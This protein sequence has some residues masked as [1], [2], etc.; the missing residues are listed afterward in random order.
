VAIGVGIVGLPVSW[1][2]VVAATLA[3]ALSAALWW[4]YFDVTSLTAERRLAELTGV[5][6]VRLARDAYTFLHLP[7]IAGVVL[8]ALGSKKALELAGDSRHALSDPLAGVGLWALF[9]G[10]ALYLLA[11]V[12]FKL[13][14]MRILSPQRLGAAVVLVALV[15]VAAEIPAL[16]SLSVVTI[17][18]V[19]LVTFETTRFAADRE[20]IRHEGT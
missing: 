3:L 7:L 11:H 4:A 6:Q 17:V 16:A 5:D 12:A 15:P 20:Q 9:G 13:R 14:V 2:I 10:V 18:T 8:V 19:G 1:P